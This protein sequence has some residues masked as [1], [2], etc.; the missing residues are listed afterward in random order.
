MN[1]KFILLIAIMI[2]FCSC[3]YHSNTYPMKLKDPKI[4]TGDFMDG[5]ETMSVRADDIKFPDWSLRFF[6]KRILPKLNKEQKLY[7]R[8]LERLRKIDNQQQKIEKAKAKS[9]AKQQK[10]Q[11]KINDL[12][13]FPEKTED[14]NSNFFLGIYSH[15][16]KRK[17]YDF[18]YN[19]KALFWGLIKWGKR[20]T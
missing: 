17:G 14:N 18:I 2:L 15:K 16:F 13:T 8:E 12:N 7:V 5:S 9:L 11:N 3:S 20:K 1:I 19:E 4:L 6:G 10:M